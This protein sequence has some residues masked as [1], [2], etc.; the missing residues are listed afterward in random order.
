MWIDNS[1]LGSWLE[2][3][4]LYEYETMMARRAQFAAAALNYGK[5]IHVALAALAL[6]CGSEYTNADLDKLYRLL[7]THFD[8]HPNPPDDHRTLGLAQETLRRYVRQ[9]EVESWQ[10]MEANGFPLVER[11]LWTKIMDYRGVPIHFYANIDKVVK[12]DNHIWIVDHK[13]TSMLGDL[14]QY[15]MAVSPQMRG[16]AW[17][18]QQ[19]FGVRPIGYVVDAI[20]SLAPTDKALSDRTALEN[21]WQN[22]FRRFGFFLYD[23]SLEEWHTMTIAWLEQMLRQWENGLWN[24]NRKSCVG[25]YGRCQFY[26]VCTLPPEERPVALQSNLFVENTWTTD[27]LK[28]KLK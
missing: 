7:E 14:F 22:Q 1:T 24:T 6:S 20:R 11:L 26:D 5:A 21:W 17:V 12:K 13:T 19:C 23:W 4:R 2:C 8:R 15:D 3:P 28:D 16:Y 9:Y 27:N 10:I 18:F 25:K